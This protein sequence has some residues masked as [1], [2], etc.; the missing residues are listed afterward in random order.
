MASGVA[1]AG[2]EAGGSLAF[3][4]YSYYELGRVEGHEDAPPDSGQV[5]LY[6]SASGPS[7]R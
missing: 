5:F 6:K 4:T 7:G 1:I 2:K 3:D